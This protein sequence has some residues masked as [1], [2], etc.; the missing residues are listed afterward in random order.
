MRAHFS[1]ISVIGRENLLL[2]DD[3]VFDEVVDASHKSPFSRI[4]QVYN[5]A[6]NGVR[7]M[8]IKLH[9]EA[10]PVLSFL[11]VAK[12]SLKV[13]KRPVNLFDSIPELI[14]VEMDDLSANAGVITVFLYPSNSVSAFVSALGTGNGNL[15]A[16]E[17]S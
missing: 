3:R 16:V 10:A 11:Q 9:L 15:R 4:G 6:R 2:I 12:V 7:P 13:A 17:K 5:C 8:T 1:R 14:R